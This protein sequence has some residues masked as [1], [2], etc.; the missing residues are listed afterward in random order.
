METFGDDDEAI[1]TTG[2]G[3]EIEGI[4]QVAT[5]KQQRSYYTDCHLKPTRRID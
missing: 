4:W 5:N 1:I 2:S 3:G